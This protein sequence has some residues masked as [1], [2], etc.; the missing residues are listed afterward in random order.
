[1]RGGQERQKVTCGPKDS[2][3]QKKTGNTHCVDSEGHHEL[4]TVTSVPS[5]ASLHPYLDFGVGGANLMWY[6]A[7]YVNFS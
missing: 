4:A 1:M 5:S 2:A 3:T 6:I 7:F